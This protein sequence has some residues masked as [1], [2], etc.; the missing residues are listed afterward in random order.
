MTRP[1]A[2]KTDGASAETSPLAVPAET[3]QSPVPAAEP[4]DNARKEYKRLLQTDSATILQSTGSKTTADGT[5]RLRNVSVGMSA[6]DRQR[7]SDPTAAFAPAQA[8]DDLALDPGEITRWA[9]ALRAQRLLALNSYDAELLYAAAQAV[10]CDAVFGD[11]DKRDFPAEGIEMGL[12][13]VIF[14]APDERPRVI[15]VYAVDQ[16][17][18]LFLSTLRPDAPSVTKSRNLL[19]KNHLYIL[20]VAHASLWMALE[21]QYR[22]Q[23]FRY[24]DATIPFLTPRLRAAGLGRLASDIRKQQEAHRLWGAS[25]EQFLLNL[26]M[27][28]QNGT[29]EQKVAE[30]AR[31]IADGTADR[32]GTTRPVSAAGLIEQTPEPDAKLQPLYQWVLFV[33]TFFPGL[34]DR[35]FTEVLRHLIPPQPQPQPP[36]ADGAAPVATPSLFEAWQPARQ[37]AIL[38]ACELH[39]EPRPSAAPSIVFIDKLFFR[40]MEQAFLTTHYGHYEHAMGRIDEARLIT[41]PMKAIRDAVVTLLANRAIREENQYGR[42]YAVDMILKYVRP[43]GRPLSEVILSEEWSA[44]LSA[45]P[46]EQLRMLFERTAAVIIQIAKTG[47]STVALS[48]VEHMQRYGFLDPLLKIL[49]RAVNEDIPTEVSA[50]AASALLRAVELGTRYVQ[51]G[52]VPVDVDEVLEGETLR[53]VRLILRNPTKGQLLT[54][55]MS[56]ASPAV[57]TLVLRYL[58]QYSLNGFR[59][60]A[61]ANP[62]AAAI[63]GM[64]DM[65]T[66]P[67]LSDVARGLF[68]DE[69]AA[70]FA[71]DLRWSL[72]YHWLAPEALREQREALE[73]RLIPALAAVLHRLVVVPTQAG[74]AAALERVQVAASVVADTCA[75][76]DEPNRRQALPRAVAHV[77]DQERRREVQLVVSAIADAIDAGIVSLQRPATGFN[78]TEQQRRS[79]FLNRWKRLRDALRYVKASIAA[80]VPARMTQ[81]R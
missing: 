78:R 39:R 73:P 9:G 2:E 29:V 38:A 13:D 49:R 40:E 70:G 37:P 34:S 81:D 4:D 41:H 35:E 11:E 45:L 80:A 44:A 36:P 21:D 48:G 66:P 26:K 62:I 28:V 68:S 57:G 7:P 71:G 19:A 18:K 63:G 6:A 25:E 47:Q 54:S 30:Y 46:S 23:S 56:K 31:H 12:N 14:S 32:L 22:G 8:Y 1:D 52:A 10:L 75:W 69:F 17:S 55:L 42:T 16:T 59:A 20:V 60:D 50:T 15:A 77:L 51:F 61:S 33:A 64:V 27:C 43:Q 74:T 67:D 3:A 79:Q 24:A 58:G 76:I 5:P 72:L 65:E 53:L